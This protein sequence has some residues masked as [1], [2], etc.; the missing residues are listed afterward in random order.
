MKKIIRCLLCFIMIVTCIHTVTAS[1]ELKDDQTYHVVNVSEDGTYETIK[2]FD[3]Y[4]EAKVSHTLLKQQYHNLGI[5]YGKTFLTVEYGVIAFDKAKDCSV[6]IEYTNDA[7][8]EVGYTN[9]CYGV[10]AAF[11]ENNMGSN[12]VKFVLSGVSGWVDGSKVTLY[13]IESVK[14]SSSYTV[15]NGYLYH[16]I[17]SD[18]TADAYDNSVRLSAAPS[19]MKEG[20][21]Y[22]SYDGHLFYDDFRKMIQNYRS[23]S[24]DLSINQKDPFYNYFQYIS[25]RTSSAYDEHAFATYFKDVLAINDSIASFYDKDNYIHDILTQSLLPQAIPAFLHYQNIYGA[26]ALL[27]LS[28]SMNESAMGKSA[29]AYNRNNLFGHAAYDSDVEKNASRYQSV[30]TSVYSHDLHYISSSYLNPDKFQYYGGFFGDKSAGM[31]VKYA[32]DPYWGEK[33]AQYAF[34]M[35]E[36]MGFHDLNRYCLGITNQSK[37]DVYKEAGSKS[38]VIYSIEKGSTFSFVLLEKTTNKE[39]TW[40]LIQTDPGLDDKKNRVKDGSYSYTSSYGYIKADVI[41]KILNKD[42]LDVKNYIP[43]TFDADGGSFYPDQKTVTLQVENGIL[44]CVTTPVKD[45][46]LFREWDKEVTVAKEK[47]TYT[48]VYDEVKEIMISQ[49]PQTSYAYGDMLDVKDGIVTIVF[50]DKDQKEIPMSNDMITGY[51]SQKEG[52]QTLNVQYAGCETTFEINVSKETQ[53]LIQ[54]L[55][56]TADEIIKNYYDKSDLSKEAMEQLSS[57]KENSKQANLNAFSTSQIRLLDAIFQ[58]NLDPKLSVIIKDTTYDLSISGISLAIQEKGLWNAVFPKTISFQVGTTISKSEKELVQKVADANHVR[59]DDVF[60]ISGKD[61][62]GGFKTNSELIFSIQKPKE[63]SNRQYMVYYIEDDDVY[64][65]PTSQTATRIVFTTEKTGSY[66]LVSTTN[67]NLKE[68][69]DTIENNTIARNGINY[70]NRFVL[71][72]CTILLLLL[73]TMIGMK[74]YLKKKGLRFRIPKK[75]TK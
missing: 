66:A 69:E 30:N 65:L 35:D 9:G 48:A 53:E 50:K 13:P 67:T 55:S 27:T 70:I 33:A 64:Q 51:D 58:T 20:V 15:E 19:Y 4:A 2:S 42:K 73:I 12:Q 61:D 36:A 8:N 56:S 34:E 26:N 16:H 68:G 71:L 40:Y 38:D 39:G 62:F 21:T 24:D 23:Q 63:H 54:S 31:N 22:Y 29:L 37:V 47:T 44:P 45:H 10:D 74:I 41:K 75:K 52:S 43:I 32:S 5:T 49:K 18:I 46:A 7:N 14:H 3:S 28:L 57:F 60:S 59:L 72:P 17:Q 6:N 11:L 1:E 25:H